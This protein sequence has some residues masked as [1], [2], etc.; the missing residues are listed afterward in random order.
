VRNQ[1]VAIQIAV[2]LAM[3][4]SRDLA[5]SYIKSH[6]DSVKA[7]LTTEMGGYLVSATGGFCSAEM[8]DDVETFFA[9]HKVA[10]SGRA[11]KHAAERINGCIEFR[12]LQEPNLKKW[13][14]AQPNP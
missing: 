9:S 11:L 10:A 12:H 6:W 3:P 7:Q 14:A 5:W 13:L 8:R 4:A 2:S 1:D